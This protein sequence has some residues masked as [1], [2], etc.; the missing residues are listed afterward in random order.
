MERKV[1][2]IIKKICED[3]NI[4][5]KSLSKGWIT[6]LTRDG[7]TRFLSGFKFDL[8]TH[9]LGII[10]DDKYATYEVLDSLDIPII[11]HNILYSKNNS[12]VYAKDSNTIEY[13]IKLFNEYNNDIVLKINNGTCGIGVYHITDIEELKNKFN[14]ISN[15]NVSFSICPFYNIKSEYRTIVIKDEELIYKKKRPIVYGNNKSTIKELLIEFNKEYFKDYDGD[16]KDI[17][18]KEGESFEYSWKFNLSG[19]AIST[20]DVSEEEKNNVLAIVNKIKNNLNLNFC[21]IDIIETYNNEYYIMEINSGVMMENFITQH[22]EG[23]D[24]AYNIYS[25]AIEELFK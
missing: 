24:I 4:E 11:K 22:E 20:L 3:K 23:Y 15:P 25:K 2:N 5:Y 9:A 14:S 13:F 7:K 16:N 17:V 18:L 12:N 1:N 6:M 10:L 21:S 8:Q 19:G